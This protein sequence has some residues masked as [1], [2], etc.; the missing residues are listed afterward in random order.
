MRRATWSTGPSAFRELRSTTTP[1]PTAP[2]DMLLPEPRGISGVPVS[3]D[4]RARTM[5]SAASTGTAIAIGVARAMPAASAYTALAPRSSRKT[6]RNSEGGRSRRINGIVVEPA[7]RLPAEPPSQHH[8]PQEWRRREPRLAIL[9]EHD[10]GDPTCR[11]D[12]HEIEERQGPHRMPGTKPHRVVDVDRGSHALLHGSHGIEHVRHEQPVDDK[13][14]RIF[15]THRFFAQ[16]PDKVVGGLDRRETGPDGRDDHH[17]WHHRHRIEKLEPDEAIRTAAGGRHRR[18]GQT[19]GIRGKNRLGLGQPIEL[20]PQMIL[21]L[22][23]LEH[24][25]DDNLPDG[26]R[27]EI[28]PEG[29][30]GQR[31]LA[32]VMTQ[33]PAL[34]GAS[35]RFLDRL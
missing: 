15:R 2:P 3:W 34:H 12:P 33:L 18:D 11:V 21:D 9:V 7:A 31:G 20:A 14:G 19:R 22:E 35:Q 8:A 6:P 13:P 17:E 29:Q 1:A 4:Q 10:L 32:I 5:T 28:G 27:L 16:S 25:L 26:C 30:T 24:G 23:V